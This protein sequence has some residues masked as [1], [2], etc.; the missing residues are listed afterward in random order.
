MISN[1]FDD[2]AQQSRNNVNQHHNNEAQNV[3]YCQ[4]FWPRPYIPSIYIVRPLLKTKMIFT[5]IRHF[6]TKLHLILFCTLFFFFC[7]NFFYKSNSHF[8]KNVFQVFSSCSSRPCSIHQPS[9]KAFTISQCTPKRCWQ[10]GKFQSS[11]PVSVFILRF[12]P[13]W[14]Q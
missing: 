11:I 12:C 2:S 13:S 8:K 5:S 7:L 9:E 1:V 3:C 10:E 14:L 4:H 6:E